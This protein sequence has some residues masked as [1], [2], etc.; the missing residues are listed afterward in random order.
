MLNILWVVMMAGGIMFA[1]FHGTMGEV[2]ETFINSSTEAVNL[3]IFMLG[4]IGLW[5]GMMEI[6]VKSGLMQ[7][8]ASMMY[9]FIHWLFP[10]IPKGHKANEYIADNMAANILGLGW[11]ATPAGLKAMKELKRR[12]NMMEGKE[13]NFG[14]YIVA[15]RK[16][17]D[18][19]LRK[20]AELVGLS[21]PYWSDIEKNRKNPPSLEKLEQIATIL[22]LDD[23]EKSE[24]LDL[25]GDQR[26]TV[27]PDI[28]AYIKE[29]DYVAVALRTARD[30]G[31]SEDDWEQFVAD[32][33][34]RKG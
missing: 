2:T 24:M 1:A 25:A 33:K 6:A 10:D 4:V 3:C 32:L 19:S 29:N 11:A 34:K 12:Q 15:K 8:A 14:D 27:A 18:I 13:R 23:T 16:E 22:G 20:M 17:K 5:N 30:L 7:R 26:D 21:A 9:P 28:P 31:A